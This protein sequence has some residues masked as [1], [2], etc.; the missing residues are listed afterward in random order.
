MLRAEVSCKLYLYFFLFIYFFH[1]LRYIDRVCCDQHFPV[2]CNCNFFIIII[3]FYSLRYI[4]QVCQCREQKFPVGI[5]FSICA[6][7]FN[8]LSFANLISLL[9][10]SGGAWTKTET[11]AHRVAAVTTERFRFLVRC[12][13][14]F[15]LS[16]GLVTWYNL[17]FAICCNVRDSK[18]LS[19]LF[20]LRAV[21]YFSFE[22]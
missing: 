12:N 8:S 19:G 15:T 10:L 18:S 13:E 11:P 21:F 16:K 9:P 14:K 4:D 7:L 20:R 22:T 17:T 6:E 5:A 2:N 3:I 1:S